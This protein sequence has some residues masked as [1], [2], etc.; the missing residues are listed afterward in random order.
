MKVTSEVYLSLTVEH[1]LKLSL[2]ILSAS[3]TIRPAITA[4]VVAIAGIMLPAIAAY[5]SIHNWCTLAMSTNGDE[6]SNI[7]LHRKQQLKKCR[8]PCKIWQMIYCHCPSS[9]I[10]HRTFT[11]NNLILRVIK[12]ST[13]TSLDH[14]NNSNIDLMFVVVS[15]RPCEINTYTWCQTWTWVECWTRMLAGLLHSLQNSLQPHH[16]TNQQHRATTDYN[17]SLVFMASVSSELC[18]FFFLISFFNY[19]S[20]SSSV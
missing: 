12:F 18:R 16:P 3:I 15:T 6:S 17:D 10:T 11:I 19:F 8:S 7:D 9:A 1:L 4:L 5:I 13:T 2:R 20:V 14:I